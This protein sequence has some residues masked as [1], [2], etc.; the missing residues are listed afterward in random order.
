MADVDLYASLGRQGA[1]TARIRVAPALAAW[2]DLAGRGAA[3]VLADPSLR[4]GAVKCFADGSL[5]STTA[6]FFDSYADAPT[7]RGLL[8]DEMQPLDGVRSRLI[9]ADAAGQ[10]VCLHAIGDRAIS[11]ALD[12]ATD[13]AAANGPRDRRFRIEHSQHVAPRDFNRYAALRVIASVQPYHAIDDGRWAEKR[14]GPERLK[15]SYAFRAF[16][17]H[18]VRLAVGSDWPVAP[19]DPALTVY[20]AVTRA[21]LD[22]KHPSGWVPAQKLTLEEAIEG[23]TMGAAYAEF[24]EHEKGSITVGKLADVVMLSGD[25][26]A[27]APA[28]LRDL[29]VHL[30]IA[31]G[32][33]VFERR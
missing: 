23:Y 8:A 28:A 3:K 6:F 18:K 4:T 24:Q 1:L 11:M 26:F 33:V 2:I 9:Q 16:L 13:V 29:A 20:A 10:Q 5:G 14:I 22:G 12:L 30:T 25:P 19:L 7:T 17:D 15:T 27:I 21:T 32:K 31:G